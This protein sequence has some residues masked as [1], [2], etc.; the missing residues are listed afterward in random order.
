M[1]VRLGVGIELACIISILNI[2]YTINLVL[3]MDLWELEMKKISIKYL[4]ICEFFNGFY[5]KH[6]QTLTVTQK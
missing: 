4:D 5:C 2:F 3:R 6:R 1:M